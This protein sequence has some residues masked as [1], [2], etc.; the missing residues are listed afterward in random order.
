MFLWNVTTCW[1]KWHLYSPSSLTVSDLV[2]A[3]N[4]ATY[5]CCLTNV[6]ELTEPCPSRQEQLLWLFL[7]SLFFELISVSEI[8]AHLYVKEEKL[9]AHFTKD[10]GK[11]KNIIKYPCL[12]RCKKQSQKVMLLT[13]PR[14]SISTTAKIKINGEREA[15]SL[16][17]R[18]KQEWP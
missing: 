7:L 16:K 5:P 2:Q 12:I 6:P 4:A 11:V 18:R 17:S 13:V 14:G 10:L 15:F 3:G 8:Q 1:V 9:C